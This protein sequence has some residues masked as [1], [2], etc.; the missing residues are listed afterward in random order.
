M[1][2]GERLTK[3]ADRLKET[4]QAHRSGTIPA[5]KQDTTLMGVSTAHLVWMVEQVHTSARLF[6][7]LTEEARQKAHRWVGFLQGCL[8][9]RGMVS[10][11][12]LRD[13]N[14]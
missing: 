1:T 10:I 11:D 8:A 9:E 4:I 3:I 2:D 7:E 12:Q 13:M 5:F 14:R 6:D